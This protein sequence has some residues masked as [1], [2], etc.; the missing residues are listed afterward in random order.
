[1]GTNILWI[2]FKIVHAK[3]HDELKSINGQKTCIVDTFDWVHRKVMP[4][5]CTLQGHTEKTKDVITCLVCLIGLPWSVIYNA[6]FS[7]RVHQTLDNADVHADEGGCKAPLHGCRTSVTHHG[8]MDHLKWYK[9]PRH[10]LHWV[11][12]K[13]H[14][15]E[16]VLGIQELFIKH[17]ER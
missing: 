14:Y 17:D 12:T 7:D 2:H 8:C 15:S 16:R 13:W 1:M 5:H 11:D 10:Y 9:D 3:R 6:T 4:K